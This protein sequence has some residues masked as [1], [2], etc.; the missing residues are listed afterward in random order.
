MRFIDKLK[1]VIPGLRRSSN[2]NRKIITD[3]ESPN[4]PNL[5]VIV[6]EDD[7]CSYMY[8][9]IYDGENFKSHV[10][11]C[12]LRNHKTA[13]NDWERDKMKE[14][15]PPMMPKAFC[16]HPKGMP[17]FNKEDLKIV[18]FEEGDGVALLEKGEVV[19]IIP[20]WSEGDNPSYSRDMI[21]D[22]GLQ[23]P[24]V[25]ENEL[26]ARV[27]KAEE[28]WDSIYEDK[29]YWVKF[30]DKNRSILEKHFG[31][32]GEYYMHDDSHWPWRLL[33]EYENNSMTYLI[34]V[35][36][37]LLP[38]PRV[39][40]AIE[41][42]EKARRVELGFAIETKTFKKY[43]DRYMSYLG[44]LVNFPWNYSTWFGHG[45]TTDSREYLYRKNTSPYLVFI[46]GSKD[47]TLPQI[48]FPKF[49][50]DHT[51]LLWLEHIT[52]KDFDLI[53]TKGIAK[54]IKNKSIK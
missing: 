18:W 30:R 34:T 4:C 49:R 39:E 23:F 44:S 46:E 54:Y 47:K 50:G 32:V 3:S 43:R 45:H 28:F 53:K 52:E 41:K 6:E 17:K 26:T 35:G 40:L 24:I 37:S 38:Q 31:K 19:G 21:E 7:R 51:N 14:G 20:N 36:M 9:V 29:N 25:E 15:T 16:N 13:P 2:Y 11:N 42:Y 8:L 5:N 48:K 33:A 27:K 22:C 1:N 10:G 12:W